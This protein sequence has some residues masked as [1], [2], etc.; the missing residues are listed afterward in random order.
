MSDFYIKQ[1]DRLPKIR[2]TLLDSAGAAVNLTGAAVQLRL[3]K[4]GV[5]TPKF[6]SAAAIVDAPFG[7]VEYLWDVT[8]TTEAGEYDAEWIVNYSGQLMTIPNANHISVHIVANLT[9][10]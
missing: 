10:T 1:G 4:R 3:R 7:V 9:G 8:D 6:T 5:K 2:S